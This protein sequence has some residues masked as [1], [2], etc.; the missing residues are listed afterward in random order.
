MDLGTVSDFILKAP[1]WFWVA[2]AACAAILVV[3]GKYGVKT[4][5]K[6]VEIKTTNTP[7]AEEYLQK[8]AGAV[9]E[10]ASEPRQPKRPNVETEDRMDIVETVE[11]LLK[12][13]P[14]GWD[15]GELVSDFEFITLRLQKGEKKVEVAKAAPKPPV[16][17]V[18]VPESNR[19]DEEMSDN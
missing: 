2:I 7:S 11:R 16:P 13:T 19:G 9:Q 17:Q 8:K 18:E 10:I 3:L 5:E 15:S 14:S 6:L 12:S 1:L 4:H